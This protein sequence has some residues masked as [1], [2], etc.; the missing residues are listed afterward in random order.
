MSNNYHNGYC[1][2]KSKATGEIH[3]RYLTVLILLLCVFL[4][5][6]CSSSRRSISYYKSHL[7][8][9]ELCTSD[10]MILL[11]S[12]KVLLTKEEG[13]SGDYINI[14]LQYYE[15][16][17]LKYYKRVSKFFNSLC[18]D[19]VVIESEEYDI[20]G[21]QKKMKKKTFRDMN[22]KKINPAVCQ[23]PYRYPFELTYTLR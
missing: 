11:T 16:N 3:A 2:R 6:S 13:E 8:E 12:G 21:F 1:M 20:D 19:G 23:F 22:G 4:F 5:V 14:H 18:Y 17:K 10:S 9:I 7:D 15:D